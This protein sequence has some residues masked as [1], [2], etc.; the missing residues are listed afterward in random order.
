MRDDVGNDYL[1]LSFDEE[2][3]RMYFVIVG[4]V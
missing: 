3:I 2:D 1:D 4:S